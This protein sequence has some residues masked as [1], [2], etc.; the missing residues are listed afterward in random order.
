MSITLNARILQ[1]EAPLI[2]QNQKGAVA[3]DL[4]SLAYDGDVALADEYVFS[5]S[6][7]LSLGPNKGAIPVAA[8]TPAASAILGVV[9]YEN[10]GVMDVQ[11]YQQR[12]GLYTNIPALKDGMIWVESTGDLDLD[13]SL[14]LYVDPD[15][16]TN[17]NKV[18]N[19]TDSGAIDISS[20]AKVEK[21]SNSDN[22]VLI[23]IFIL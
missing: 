11:G 18:R 15:D 23:R 13:S 17:Y 1:S 10:S 5:Y 2:S 14:W 19:G 6:Q 21:V 9:K 3:K 12:E 16:T 8:T 4:V 7:W 22:L 20:I